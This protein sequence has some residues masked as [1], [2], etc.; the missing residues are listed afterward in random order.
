MPTY[1]VNYSS[2]DLTPDQKD[3]IARS[4]T[5]THNSETGA[6]TYFAQVLFNAAPH[7]NHFIGGRLVT[8]PQ[9]FLH[10]QIRAGRTPGVKQK[11]ILG[12]RDVLVEV[13]GLD[14]SQIWVYLVELIPSQ[15][16][17]YGE[18]LPQSGKESDWFAGLSLR[19]KE[20]LAAMGK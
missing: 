1:T 15:M 10:G 14:R 6:N 20:K 17:E 12:L 13:S 9:L 2:I 7:G 19:L 3:R 5:K 8:E 18:I 16:I 11:L 4:I